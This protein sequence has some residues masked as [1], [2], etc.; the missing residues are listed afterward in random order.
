MI[1]SISASEL[2]SIVA[3]GKNIELIDVRTPMEFRA[4]HVTIARNEPLSGLDQKLFN[5]L[6]MELR[7][8]LSML[9]VAQVVA[10]SKRARSSLLLE[11]PT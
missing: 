7:A 10:A 8:S 6:A 11:S 9:S 5:Q 4:M 2:S 3:S 1:K